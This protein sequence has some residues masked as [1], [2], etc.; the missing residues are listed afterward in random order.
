MI[1][2]ALPMISKVSDILP[3]VPSKNTLKSNISRGVKVGAKGA[4]ALGV[5]R[6]GMTLIPASTPGPVKE[7]ISIIEPIAVGASTGD[8]LATSLGALDSGRRL[9][10]ALMN[11][12]DVKAK[13]PTFGIGGESY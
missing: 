12:A 4:I 11:R 5:L 13:V 6:L 3:E 10:D 9:I 2:K 1:I 7:G 8:P